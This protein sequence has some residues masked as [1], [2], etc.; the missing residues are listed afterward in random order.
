MDSKDRHDLPGKNRKYRESFR[1][2]F[3]GVKTAFQEE[4]NMRTHVITGLLVLVVSLFLDLTRYEWLWLILVSYLVFV[5]EL[6]NTVVEN[7]VDLV[8]EEFHP[9]A[10][11]VKDMAAAVVLVTAGFAALV[12]III[13][14]P[15][16]LQIFI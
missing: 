16:L 8:T 9:I 6:I 13:L 5:M 11:K 1:Y 2:A 4:R 3:W 15:K 10:K 12:G 14:L 7:V